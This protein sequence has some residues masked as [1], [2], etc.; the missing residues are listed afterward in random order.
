MAGPSDAEAVASLH[1]DSW[2]K[3]YRGAYS[4][5]FLDGDVFGD[6]NAVWTERLHS[7]NIET[8]TFLAEDSAGLVG[9][10]HTALDADPMWGALLDNLHVLSTHHRQGIGAALM[11][12]SAAFVRTERPESGLYLWALEQNVR[13][14][15]FYE[16]QGGKRADTARV[17]AV[18]RAVDGPD[19]APRCFRYVWRDPSSLT[20]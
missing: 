11:S 20:G 16:A 1:A 4:D 7:G 14:Q 18:D 12:R 8:E 13:A 3:H 15:K 9:F 17:A 6:R 10:V 19:G 5:A 2:R